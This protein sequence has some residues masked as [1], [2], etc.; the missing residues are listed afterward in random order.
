MDQKSDDQQQQVNF[1][2]DPNKTP[3]YYT[4]G[5]LVSS[6]EN[7]VILSF[8]Q[9]VNDGSQQNIVARVAMPLPQAKAFLATLNDHL[10]K[11]ER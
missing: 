6:N 10:E 11:F 5:Y 7:T 3:V 9:A 2:I 8:S 4:D 1:N